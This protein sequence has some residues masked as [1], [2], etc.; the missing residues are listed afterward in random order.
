MIERPCEKH[1]YR[2]LSDNKQASELHGNAWLSFGFL[3]FLMARP[4][5]LAQVSELR[6]HRNLV[7]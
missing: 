4:A 1:K 2:T 5:A 6:L 3:K 7:M